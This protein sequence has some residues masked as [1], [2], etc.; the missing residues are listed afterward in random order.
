M[1]DSNLVQNEFFYQTGGSTQNRNCAAW[2]MAMVWIQ[3]RGIAIQMT[4]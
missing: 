4:I 3:K 2:V 1:F